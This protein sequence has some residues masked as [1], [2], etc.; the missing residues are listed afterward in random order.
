VH[1][2][3][4][5]ELIVQHVGLGG[6]RPQ[7]GPEVDSCPDSVA[8]TNALTEDAAESE[9]VAIH[10]VMAIYLMVASS[11]CRRN[12][13]FIENEPYDRLWELQRI[14]FWTCH[15]RS[16]RAARSGWRRYGHCS[17]LRVQFHRPRA[18]WQRLVRPK[19]GH[20]ELGH[21]YLRIERHSL[22]H[23]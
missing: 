10:S 21:Q 12:G 7:T 4:L 9:M 11:I 22:D 6:V 18:A 16:T 15:P 17:G 5:T 20:V 8:G 3:M 13:N 19:R 14:S 1:W 2:V 23:R